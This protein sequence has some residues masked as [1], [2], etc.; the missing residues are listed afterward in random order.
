MLHPII[1]NIAFAVALAFTGASFATPAQAAFVTTD[2]AL[3]QS[4]PAAQHRADFQAAL[5]RDDVRGTLG[6]WGIG[7]DEA[8]ARVQAMSDV[9]I[10]AMASNIQNDPAGQGAGGAIIGAAVTVFIVLLITDI[11]GFTNVFG[12]VR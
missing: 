4:S 11:L 9:E 6:Q 10:L 12:F 3:Q 2:Q 7:S 8:S 1:R 5:A